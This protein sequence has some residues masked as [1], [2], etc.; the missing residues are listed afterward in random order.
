MGPKCR[1]FML[2]W[3]KEAENNSTIMIVEIIIA[4][5]LVGFDADALRKVEFVS[6]FSFK[7]STK[8]L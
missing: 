5:L 2:F 6:V 7:K 1:L 4:F 8:K 3:N